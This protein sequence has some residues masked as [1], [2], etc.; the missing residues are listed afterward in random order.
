M[1]KYLLTEDSL[2][3]PSLKVTLLKERPDFDE[4]VS[5]CKN[6]ETTIEQIEYLNPNL[7]YESSDIIIESNITGTE[8]WYNGKY[9]EIHKDFVTTCKSLLNQRT[10]FTKE[11][12]GNFLL[13]VLKNPNYSFTNLGDFIFERKFNFLD[14]GNILV[15]K[16]Y[17]TDD[18]RRVNRLIEERP[19]QIDKWNTKVENGKYTVVEIDPSEIDNGMVI[20]YRIREVTIFNYLVCSYMRFNLFSVVMKIVQTT[21]K[22]QILDVLNTVLSNNSETILN[23]YKINILKD[24][25]DPEDTKKVPDLMKIAL[26]LCQE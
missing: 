8:V 14:N 15:Y 26:R 25:V 4:V 19:M 6:P 1:I 3:I 12:L 22:D 21:E 23:T 24:L 2:F 9:Y 18:E 11:V 13:K 20:N 5:L 10:S 17:E 7:N 16:K